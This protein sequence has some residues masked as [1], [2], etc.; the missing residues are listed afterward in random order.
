MFKQKQ[1][2]GF[3][4]IEIMVAIALGLLLLAGIGQVYISNY[5]SSRVAN[6]MARLQE[7]GRFAIHFLAY[8]IRQAGNF[9]GC[10]S[11]ATIANTVN[12]VSTDWILGMTSPVRGYDGYPNGGDPFP[13]FQRTPR[14]GTDA[15]LVMTGGGSG[16]CV[17][18]AHVPASTTLHCADTHTFD[19]GD[20]LGVCDIANQH[21]A[22]FQQINVNTNHTVSVVVHSTGN[23]EYPGNCTNYL[24]S[25]EPDP[26]DNLNVNP[27]GGTSYQFTPGSRIFKLGAKAFYV[28]DRSDGVPALYMEEFDSANDI[29]GG[30][31]TQAVEL[32]E[33]VEDL[34]IRY[35]IDTDGD[36]SVD[37]YVDVSGVGDWGRVM[38]VRISVLVRTIDDNLATTVQTYA[39]DTDDDGATEDHTATDMRLRQVFNSTINLRNATL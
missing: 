33:G 38:A 5:Q 35:G 11:G 22:I 39:Y 17:V 30:S 26:C 9:N 14:N 7:S 2:S 16:N 28:A 36:L 3:G 18:T 8:D 15:I 27:H 13:T 4:L 34:Q 21:L 6:E 10:T 25:P 12:R 31:L 37:S 23:T 19:H 20:I 32:A 24:G 29:L 1:Q